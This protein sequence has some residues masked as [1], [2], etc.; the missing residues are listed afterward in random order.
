MNAVRTR[1]DRC[2]GVLRLHEAADGF[3]ARLRFPGGFVTPDALRV[4]ARAT[5]ELGDG[6][7]ELT[8]RGNLQVRGLDARAADELTQRAFAAGLVPSI[9]HDEVRNV[10]ASPLAGLDR[11]GGLRDVVA[12]LDRAILADPV[13]AGLTGRFLFGLDDGRGD[14]A[15]LRPDALAVLDGEHARVEGVPVPRAQVAARLVDVAH[16][17]LDERRAQGSGAWRVAELDDGRARVRAR[18]GAPLLA[19]PV[20]PAPRLPIGRV[21]RADGGYALVVAPPLGRLT[22]EQAH[23]LA[24]HAAGDELRITTSRRIVLPAAPDPTDPAADPAT[25]G[26]VVDPASPWL[27]VSACAGRPRC[28]SALADV[29][30]DAAR[31]LGRWP[32][33]RVHWSGCARRCGRT[34]DVQVDVVATAQGYE[35]ETADA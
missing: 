25:V 15:A 19:A 28:A 2:P 32:G 22:A 1:A 20:P 11:L 21:A 17:F 12:A 34:A 26:L 23:W 5:A 10:V 9:S 27:T 31:S 18:L 8:S 24:D 29:Q 35:I 13:L 14:I 30:S 16:A 7:L 6:R 3:L 33:R 4:L